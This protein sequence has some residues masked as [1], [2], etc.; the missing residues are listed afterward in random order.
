MWR[1]GAAEQINRDEAKGEWS[2][3]SVRR[4]SQNR[5]ISEQTGRIV[6]RTAFSK[7]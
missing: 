5:S 3:F 4:G 6:C 7:D 2:A 1:P